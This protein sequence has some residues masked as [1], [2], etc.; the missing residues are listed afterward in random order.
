[1]EKVMEKVYKGTIPSPVTGK[2]CE[3]ELVEIIKISPNLYLRKTDY[4]ERGQCNSAFIVWAHGVCI[5]DPSTMEAAQEMLGEIELLIKK[6]V[7]NVFLTHNHD[8]H[9]D[10]MPVFYQMPV[11]IYCSYKCVRDISAKNDGPSVVVGVKGSLDLAFGDVKVELRTLEEVTHS[12]SDMLIRLPNDGVVC[13]GDF[14]GDHRILYFSQANPKNWISNL[15]ELAHGDDKFILPGHGSI[16]PAEMILET[17]Q[18]LEVL[19]K[20]AIECIDLYLG[21]QDGLTDVDYD[22]LDAFLMQ[23]LERNGEKAAIIRKHAEGDAQRE[24]RMMVRKYAALEPWGDGIR[25]IRNM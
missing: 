10:G 21:T 19:Q 22:K 2:I 3:G 5:V 16:Y 24:L 17:A 20:A 15:Y 13:T 14:A 18:Y 6:P 25:L 11:T 9:V 4:N 12:P 1:M 23:Y 7:R 8:D